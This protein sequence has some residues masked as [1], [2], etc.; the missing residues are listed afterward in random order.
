MAVIGPETLGVQALRDPSVGPARLERVEHP[1]RAAGPGLALV[2]VTDQ[3]GEL[4]GIE[5]P[6]GVGVPFDEPDAFLRREHAQLAGED[7][8]GCGR[9]RVHEDDVAELVQRVAQHPHHRCDAAAGRDEQD[10]RRAWLRQDELAAG[11]VEVNE[12]P[13]ARAAHEVGADPAVG[14]RLD[15]D[16]DAAVGAVDR[17]RQRVRAPLAHAVDV[18]A[19]ADVL[20]RDVPGPAA[21]RPDHQRHG[22]AGLGVDR[23]DP[24]AQVGTGP[25]RVDEVEVVG[26]QQRRRHQ[27]H[28]VDRAVAQAGRDVRGVEQSWHGLQGTCRL[29]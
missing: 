23:D 9:R 3:I 19:D 25:H 17:R 13:D 24:S 22:V 6:V 7:D 4:P 27:A 5:H 2:E 12:H 20:A 18:E 15:G 26:R 10:L 29:S 28:E 21:S 14:D 11:L 16:R 1:G 8:V